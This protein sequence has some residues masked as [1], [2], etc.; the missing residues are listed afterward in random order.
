[1]TQIEFIK[2]EL[3]TKG[4][5]SRNQCLSQFISR[6]GAH[7]QTLEN[8]GWKFKAKHEGTDY[9]YELVLDPTKL[10]DKV[11]NKE[12]VEQRVY[13]FHNPKLI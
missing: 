2:N 8:K 12:V 10:D 11:W 1:M 6:L 3:R 9:V 4:R 13:D 7:I 5:I